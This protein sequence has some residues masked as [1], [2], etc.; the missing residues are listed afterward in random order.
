MICLPE[1]DL[2]IR[3]VLGEKGKNTILVICLNPSTANSQK[4]DGTTDNIEKI[5]LVNGY[6]GWVLFNL[7]PERTPH[8]KDLA[9]RPNKK[10]LDQNRDTLE[11]L[12]LNKEWGIKNVWLAWGNEILKRD[13]LK[14]QAGLILDRLAK[15]QLAYWHIK[16]TMKGH[17][18]HPSKQSINR[19]I[20]PVGDIV[21]QPFNPVV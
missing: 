11:A 12:V 1:N 2:R 7:S 18:F 16:K 9:M 20:G 17:P 3:F 10:E 19:Y 4:H 5:A 13:Y 14:E 21:L 8:P 6:D 15:H